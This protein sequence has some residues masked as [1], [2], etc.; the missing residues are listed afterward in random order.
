M[1]N[2][3]VTD[4]ADNTSPGGL[5]SLYEWLTGAQPAS[6]NPGIQP[7][8]GV[9]SRIGRYAIERKLGEG[10]MGVV[11]AARDDRLERTIALKT[12][13]APASDDTA[14]QRVW[15]EARAAASV[16]HPNICQIYE[17]GED[18]GALFIAMELLEGESLSERLKSGPMRISEAT[19]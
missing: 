16:N 17:V 2:F 6:A 14:R 1:I 8:Q 19:P 5:R 10:G 11:Y 9:P 18:G 12:L 4:H 15:R 7:E 13:S 3:L